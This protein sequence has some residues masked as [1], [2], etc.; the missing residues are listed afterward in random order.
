M[1]S[2]STNS[3]EKSDDQTDKL[4]Q[5]SQSSDQSKKI[6]PPSSA[7]VK[8][9]INQQTVTTVKHHVFLGIAY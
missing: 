1:A 4:D 8:E 6:L 7:D 2:S 5:T 9:I 3:S